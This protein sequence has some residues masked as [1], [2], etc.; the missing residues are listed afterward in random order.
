MK[1]SLCVCVCWCVYK[2]QS[3]KQANRRGQW[4]DKWSGRLAGGAHILAFSD[5]RAVIC[6]DVKETRADV[7]R[8]RDRVPLIDEDSNQPSSFLTDCFPFPV[9]VSTWQQTEVM[10]VRFPTD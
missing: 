1:Y 3:V 10:D 7:F 9:Q 8:Y 4:A 2:L 6:G 5:F